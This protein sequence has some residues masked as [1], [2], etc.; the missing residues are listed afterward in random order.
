MK[1]AESGEGPAEMRG[2]FQAIQNSCGL[3]LHHLS[4]HSHAE[5]ATDQEGHGHCQ[6]AAEGNAQRCPAQRG[7]AEIAAKRAES[8]KT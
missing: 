3:G 4:P 1:N 2:Q 6:S 8:R 5:N 7:A